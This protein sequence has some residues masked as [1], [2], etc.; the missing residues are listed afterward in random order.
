VT[1]ECGGTAILDGSEGLELLE[2]QARSIPVEEVLALH[3]EDVGH[4]QGG[5]GH[6]LCFRRER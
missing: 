1:S 6:F 2:I 4:L 5:P 3:A